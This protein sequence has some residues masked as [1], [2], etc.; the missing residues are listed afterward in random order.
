M[1]EMGCLT[2]VASISMDN[3]TFHTRDAIEPKIVEWQSKDLEMF[4]LPKYS[5]RLIKIP[6]RFI[7]YERIE[8]WW[9]YNGWSYLVKYVEM[10]IRV[11]GII[12]RANS[13]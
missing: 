11:N 10:I 1:F 12:K 8:W 3:S 9:A 7:K 2:I 13:V 6:W 4:Y 5:P